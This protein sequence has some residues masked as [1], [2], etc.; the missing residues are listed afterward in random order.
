MISQLFSSFFQSMEIVD[1]IAAKDITGASVWSES[2][3]L[4]HELFLFSNKSILEIY[5]FARL[6]TPFTDLLLFLSILTCS[7]HPSAT[8]TQNPFTLAAIFHDLLVAGLNIDNI[9]APD[10]L[11][12][13]VL[14]FFSHQHLSGLHFSHR[15]ILLCNFLFIKPKP[16]FQ[17]VYLGLEFVVCWNIGRNHFE[18]ARALILV[19]FVLN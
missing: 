18:Y 14:I 3:A 10:D 5:F 16:R 12:H 1:E 9:F 15:S 2:L 17:L 11:S 13:F 6:T 8:D 7:D 4:F 19:Q